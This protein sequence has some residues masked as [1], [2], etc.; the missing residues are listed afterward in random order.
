MNDLSGISS[1]I[2]ISWDRALDPHIENSAGLL[3]RLL[4]FIRR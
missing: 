3:A 4:L 2:G 1:A